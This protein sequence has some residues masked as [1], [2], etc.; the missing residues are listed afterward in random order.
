MEDLMWCLIL[1]CGWTH[2]GDHQD[3]RDLQSLLQG[4]VDD[5]DDL[6]DLGANTR[7][8]VFKK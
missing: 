5:A 3:L 2:P 8:S 4:G 6:Q 7:E 1:G